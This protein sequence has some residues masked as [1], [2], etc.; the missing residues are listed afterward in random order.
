M[1]RRDLPRLT[2][3]GRAA[4]RVLRALCAG[5]AAVLWRV[6]VD[7]LERLPVAGP[8]VLAPVH[9]SYVDFLVVAVAVPRVMRFMVKNSIWK[10]RGLGWAVAYMGS[11]PVDRDRPDREALRHCEQSIEGGDPV[12][13]FPEGQRRSGDVVEELFDGPAWVACRYR[14]PVVPVGLG[15]TDR[16]MPIG[17]KMIRPA[18]VRVVIG[19]PIYPEVPATGRVPRRLVGEL[20]DRLRDEVQRL[21]DE[22]RAA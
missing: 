13:M 18:R 12:V 14:V 8:F 2:T 1:T 16:A 4:Y 7:G 22:A 20:T 15:G 10:S 9:R 6:E 11:F 21:Y 17:A 19:E 5:A 3:G